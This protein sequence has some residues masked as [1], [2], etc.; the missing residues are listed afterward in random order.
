MFEREGVLPAG[1]RV[2]V[3]PILQAQVV[4]LDGGSQ[5][6]GQI[7][8]TIRESGVMCD[9]LP[10]DTPAEQLVGRKAIIISGGPDSVTADGA[11]Q[12]DPAVF[13][14]G[15]PALGICYGEQ[16]MAHHLGGT[17]GNSGIREDGKVNTT[18]FGGSPLFQGIE[19]NQDVWM[20][21]GDSVLE[22]PE[23]FSVVGGHDDMIAAIADEERRLY[24]LQF[25]P[26]V[27]GTPE[28]ETIIANFLFGIS[29]VEKDFT[30][31]DQIELALAEIREQAGD[32]PM[33]LFLSGGVDS[34]VEALLVA[35]A[36]PA[37]QI[38]A[39]HV[40]T[41]FMRAD[42][43]VTVAQ[44]LRSQGIELEV[45][46]ASRIFF[47]S[48]T[49]IDGIETPPL[50]AVLDPQIKRQIIGNTF[51]SVFDELVERLG[52]SDDIILAQGTL[53]PDI[54]ESGSHLAGTGLATIKT[55]HNDTEA[56]REL[57][58]QGRV[59][60]PLKGLYKD[61]VR[62]IGRMLGLPDEFVMRQ[63]F[64]GPGLAIR[65]IGN[66]G[67][68][69]NRGALQPQLDAFLT[70]QAGITGDVMPFSTVGVQGDARSYSALAVLRTNDQPDWHRLIQIADTIPRNVHGINRVAFAFENKNPSVFSTP[71]FVNKESVDQLRHADAIVRAELTHAGLDHSLSQ[72]PV[73]LAPIS[74]GKP[75]GR[76]IAIRPFSTRDFMT[77]KPAVPG[78][79]IPLEVLGTVVQRLLT[80]VPGITQVLYD[81]S[82]KPPATTEW[83]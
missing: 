59:C 49:V 3:E 78:E 33:A 80:E 75:G 1:E 25:H 31:D 9:I 76:S 17:V 37:E 7:D 26:E 77:G 18:F 10:I 48:T 52:F 57:R 51:A 20:S 39:F 6:C 69:T 60:E 79:D 58:K 36:L 54:I 16:L 70:D 13:E 24:G 47:N 28:G 21:H 71:T 64:P 14:L 72:V 82:S 74:Y 73:I 66:E 65:V 45:I 15:I 55:H 46:D 35:K 4:V 56:I 42:E 83:E 63:P 12:C 32:K 30:P 5:F 50:H 29:E 44:A 67:H 81:L 2:E 34:T 19:T 8:R 11:R 43:S 53:R 62:E 22:V 61:Q 41:G 38:Y 68:L 27:D 23:G 40:D